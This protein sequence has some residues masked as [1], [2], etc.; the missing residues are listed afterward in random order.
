MKK[1]LL[2]LFCLLVCMGCDQGYRNDR[3]EVKNLIYLIGDGMG[4]AQMCMLEV[5][6]DYAPTA[7]TEA[8]HVSLITTRSANNRVTDSAAAGTAL[9]SGA[10]TNNSTLGMATDSVILYSMMEDARDK[11]LATGLVV[12]CYL[13][14]ATPA[15]F[16]A[17]VWKRHMTEQITDDLVASNFV[18]VFQ[19]AAAF[20]AFVLLGFLGGKMIFD[21][22]KSMKS[23]ECGDAC[24]ACF[25]AEKGFSLGKLTVQAIA[26]SIDAL[27]VGITLRMTALMEGGLALGVFGSVGVIGV[28]TFALSL[29]A[30]YIGKA[31]GGNPLASVANGNGHP[32]SGNYLTH[33]N[34][35]YRTAV[36]YR[37]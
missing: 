8:E 15:A 19:M 32:A 36:I 13:Q 21:A 31:V 26:T 16:Y 37:V 10:K 3:A 24:E 14:H 29:T 33:G 6:N 35:F 22:V 5:E 7:F 2:P 17:H 1:L 9:A 18:E 25:S 11:G 27:A 4:L 12:S 23:C 20:I 34:I 30:V 28:V